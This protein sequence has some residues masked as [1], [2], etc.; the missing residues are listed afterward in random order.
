MRVERRGACA[1]IFLF[2]QQ[3]SEFAVFLPQFIVASIKHLRKAA[4]TYV[5]DQRCFV[6]VDSG[7]LFVLDFA[8]QADGCDVLS[9]FLFEG[10]FTDAVGV[11]DPVVGL[12]AGWLYA[13][14]SFDSGGRRM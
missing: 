3:F 13:D 5:F 2:G 14:S 7:P 9:K 6:C 11:G 12:V 10:T 4:P 8:E 1:A